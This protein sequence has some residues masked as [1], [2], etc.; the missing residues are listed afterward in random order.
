MSGPNVRLN[1]PLVNC[2]VTTQ[3]NDSDFVKLDGKH[4]RLHL[5]IESYAFSPEPY[6]AS[7]PPHAWF[8]SCLTDRKSKCASPQ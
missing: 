8:A 2:A 4:K 7:S 1:T 3:Q 5:V 6:R